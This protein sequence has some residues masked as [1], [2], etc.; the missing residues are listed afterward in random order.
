MNAPQPAMD[1]QIH[2]QGKFKLSVG[3]HSVAGRKAQNEDAIGIRIPDGNLLSTKGAAAVI[4]DGVSAAEAGKE[5]SHTCVS[6]FLSDYF[7]TPETWSVKQSGAQVLTAL[8]RWLYSRGRG[9]NDNSKGYIT[10][11]STVIF[12]SHTAHIFHVGDSRIYRL[13]EGTLEQL[14]TDHSTPVS[15]DHAYLARAMGLD[16]RLDVDYQTAPLQSEDIFLQTTDGVHDVLG[17]HAIQHIL[18]APG[19]TLDKRCEQLVEVALHKGSTDNLSCQLLRVDELPDAQVDDVLNQFSQLQFPPLLEPGMSLD[20][21]RIMRELQGGTRSHLYQVE[22]MASGAHYCMKTP[23]ANFARDPVY[24]DRFVLESWIGSRINSPYVVKVVEPHRPKS[25][26]YYLT[27]YVQ[28]MTLSQWMR[29][30]PKPAV[31]EAVFLIDQIARGIRALHRRE[32]LHQNIKPDNILIDGNG[33]VKI[34]DFSACHMAGIAETATPAQG[35]L[36]PGSASYFAPEYTL[37]K[38][39]NYRA[40]LFSLAVISYEMFTGQLPFGG[41]LEHCK[42]Q[43]DFL[44]T[45]Y[46]HSYKLNPLVPHWIDCALK[47]ALRF[48]EERRHGDVAEF[49]YEL[50]HPNPRY[51]EY[52]QRP[53]MERDPLKAW[54]IIAGILALSQAASLILLLR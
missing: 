8:N 13:R 53:L 32:T 34:M 29:E 22:D 38:T 14:T 39:T 46:T 11:M 41:V 15:Q 43:R 49:V 30:H 6:S 2:P 40:D 35:N 1:K 23:S 16:V 27:E 19:I 26:L 24:I 51:L 20:G 10:T 42:S 54:K 48:E 47:K 9:F 25:C 7:S 4:A 50:Q 33:Q 31:E 18:E 45:S 36:T 3:Q 52:H 17:P 44:A 37:H 21:Y 28:G 12:K 5:A